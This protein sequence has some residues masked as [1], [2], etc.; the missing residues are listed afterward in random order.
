M[1][2]KDTPTIV[3]P[4]C[5]QEYFPSEV[6][7]PDKVFGNA[8]EVVKDDS[9]KISFVIGEDMDLDEEYTCDNCGAKMK[10]HANI[11]FEVT[12]N[13]DEQEEEEFVSSFEAAKKI[14]LPE[15][16]LF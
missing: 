5:G 4:I 2:T 8:K 3:C 14:T 12:T 9:G 13:T 10:I 15:E 11:N 7:Y 1:F 16:S 6:F